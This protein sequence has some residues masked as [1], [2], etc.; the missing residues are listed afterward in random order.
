M[1]FFKELKAGGL[2]DDVATRMTQDYV[3]TFTKISDFIRSGAARG[4]E[5]EDIKGAIYAKLKRELD[6]EAK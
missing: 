1:T 3:A 4:K 2:P 5:D 6:K